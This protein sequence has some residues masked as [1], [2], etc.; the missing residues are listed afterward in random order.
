MNELQ[1]G[2]LAIGVIVVAAVIGYNKWQEHRYRNEAE[3]GMPRGRDDALMAGATP[4]L[5]PGSAQAIEAGSGEATRVEPRLAPGEPVPGDDPDSPSLSEMLDFMVAIEAL[6]DVEGAA[7]MEAS[8]SAFGGFS[9]PVG[10]EGYNEISTRWEPLSPGKR[11][12]LLRVGLQL[13][14]RRG[15][16]SAEELARFGATVHQVAAAVEALASLPDRDDALRVAAGLDSFCSEVDIL[17]ALGVAGSPENRFAGT[18]LRALAESA[19]LVLENDG[20]FRR[21]DDAGRVLYEL[22]SM[23]ADPFTAEGMRTS[24]VSGITL[25]IDIPRAPGVIR[26]FELFRDLARHL[27]QGLGGQLVDD[28]RRALSAEALDQIQIKVDAVHRAMQNRGIAA[29]SP[30]ALR[31]FS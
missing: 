17:I 29:G 21:R 20:R 15:A 24:S 6:T 13:V 9:K 22:A 4:Q 11:Y 16:V 19:G 5:T 28:N 2:L 1:I 18:K 26:T 31:L 7:L 23:D 12:S 30:V 27:A 8:A 3:R 25:E 10:L 14:D